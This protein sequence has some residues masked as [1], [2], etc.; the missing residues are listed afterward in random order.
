MDIRKG[1]TL[2]EL[3]VVIA[4]IAI[5]SMLSVPN[6]LKYVAKA[7]RAEAF[8]NL[9][10]LACAQKMFYAEHGRYTKNLK[11]DLGWKPEGTCQYTY[12]LSDGNNG[13]SH[14][15]GQLNTPSSD[16]AGAHVSNDSFVLY[17]AGTIYGNK[18]DIISIDH[19][20]VLTIVKDS[21]VSSTTVA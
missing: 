1:F 19:N 16:L 5:L 7:K 15:V 13:E 10:S 2:I 21:L 9:R 11:A 3:M 18:P 12:G 14:F 6:L 20:N 8:M 17:A 4:I